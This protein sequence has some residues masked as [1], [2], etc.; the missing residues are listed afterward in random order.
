MSLAFKAAFLHGALNP[1]TVETV[2]AAGLRK[3]DV[4]VRIKAAGLCHT[5][6]EV[7][8]GSLRYP[9]PII[10]GHEAAG[11]V[12]EVGP[13]ARE[14]RVGDQVVLSWNPHCGDCYRKLPI[15]CEAYLAHGP[16]A[17]AF[18]GLSRA[19]L[20]DG[21]ELRHLMYLGAFGERGHAAISRCL[22]API[23]R[24]DSSSTS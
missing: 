15:L 7:I 1:L 6:L 5:H 21:R 23:S 10:L 20:P 3:D 13:E 11:V 4:L 2:Y 16:E 18:D 14:V 19:S 24:A 8:G 17:L 12:E 22:R 9:M